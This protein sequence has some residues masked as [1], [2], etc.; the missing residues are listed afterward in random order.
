M[1]RQSFPSRQRG[2]IGILAKLAV[3]RG[4]RRSP[5]T[6][7]FLRM[8]TTLPDLITFTRADAT[9]CATRRRIT[10]SVGPSR[11]NHIRNN[12]MIGA[13]AGTPGTMPTGWTITGPGAL[14]NGVQ[15]SIAGTGTENGMPY[16]DL[17]F[18]GTS[19][20]GS[21]FFMNTISGTLP[22]AAGG[23]SWVGSVFA[24]LVA[25]SAP[26]VG[27][28]SVSGRDSGGAPTGSDTATVAL[29]LG[30]TLLRASIQ[31]TFVNAS[32][33]FVLQ[34]CTFTFADGVTANCTIRIAAPQLEKG[35]VATPVI[36]TTTAAVTTTDWPRTNKC[37]NKTAN[38][39][40]NA[41][42][43]IALQA[44]NGLTTLSVVDDAAALEAAGL[45]GICTSGRVYKFDNS[46]GDSTAT[47]TFEGEV[48]SLAPH[49]ASCF[50]RG[51]GDA[52][53][54]INALSAL[55]PL[56]AAYARRKTENVT[57]IGTTRDSYISLGAGGV[58]YAILNQLEEGD[59]ATAV[60]PNDTGAAKTVVTPPYG[61]LEVLAANKPRIAYTTDGLPRGLLIE[62][63]RTNKC[64]NNNS[65]PT[66]LTGVSKGGDAAATLAVVDDPAALAAAGLS[67]IC[68]T[69]KVYKL[70]NGAGVAVA[71][72]VFAGSVGNT[73]AH[74]MT[75]YARG[76]GSAFVGV[77]ATNGAVTALGTTY[78]RLSVTGTPTGSGAQSFIAAQPGAVVYFILNQ[79]EEASTASSVI[80]GN[81]TRAAESAVITNLASVNWSAGGWSA[82]VEFAAPA[83][84]A[85]NTFPTILS[86]RSTDGQD[87]L[88]FWINSAGAL[89]LKVVNAN[90]NV[91]EQSA[92]TVT[93]SAV[94]RVTFSVSATQ[95]IVSLNGGA[96]FTANATIRTSLFNLLR[97]G[98]SSTF[99]NTTYL[100]SYLRRFK[101]WNRAL[102]QGELQSE[103]TL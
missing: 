99:S 71:S 88:D 35:T 40:L 65:D 9:P 64:T 31:R 6:L 24:K 81:K 55:T 98:F 43:S 77:S 51:T 54:R 44:T 59:A 42:V 25:G 68:S 85:A 102:T 78:A 66:D 14:V 52:E 5:I 58:C 1:K 62:P 72:A 28:T 32:T 92:G 50:M 27:S 23:Q 90:V 15:G 45:H 67:G 20:G 76:S 57:P 91:F 97:L 70:D 101:A 86:L 46:L 4:P 60:I 87:L 18:A 2:Y 12:S 41:S 11:T 79:L 22:T 36:P 56:T 53:L 10:G 29:S 47:M 26:T 33:V 69:G 8:D 13:V 7:D 95:A 80:D 96:P 89:I 38:A 48:S 16:I 74:T 37:R 73:N 75:A 93:L 63:S 21:T 39:E 19:V 103:S 94:N 84:V 30:S 61:D 17:S 34:Y 82:M 49:S 83:A 3:L 100:G